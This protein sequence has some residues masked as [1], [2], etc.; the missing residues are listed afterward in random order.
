[1]AA[2]SADRQDEPAGLMPAPGDFP[3]KFLIRFSVFRFGIALALSLSNW[4]AATPAVSN[5]VHMG[6]YGA[7]STAVTGLM[8]QSFALQN[9]SGNIANSQTVGFKRVETSFEDMVPDG[10]PSKLASGSVV[11]SARSTN[12]VQGDISSSQ[13][14]TNMAINGNGFFVVQQRTGQVDGQSVFSGANLFTRRGDFALDKS[15]FLVNGA[16]N[17][18]EGLPVDPTT[19]NVSGSVPSVIKISN[20]LLPALATTAINYQVNLPQGA[21]L[22]NAGDF[23]PSTGTT[24]ATITGTKSLANDTP[25]KSTGTTDISGILGATPSPGITNGQGLKITIG[26]VSKTIA[27]NST[28]TPGVGEDG[29]LDATTATGADLVAKINSLFAGTQASL[30]PTT[31]ALVIKAGNNTDATS[32]ADETAAVPGAVAALG[33][34]AAGSPSSS[35][36]SGLSNSLSIQ[37]GTGTAV[38]VNLTGVKDSAGF[39]SAVQSAIG[40]SGTASINSST[41]DLTITAANTADK[42]TLSGTDTGAIGFAT[43]T[44]DPTPIPGT[45][46]VNTIK[47]SDGDKFLTESLSGG[48]I[49]A[50]APNGSPANVQFR[51]AKTANT[52][53]GGQDTWSLYY[54]SNPTA[55]GSNPM[56]TSTGQAYTF[57]ADGSLT[58]AVNSTTISNLTVGGV[59]LGDI[60]L[61]HGANGVTEF[62]DTNGTVSTTTLNQD[63]YA[64][65]KFTSVSI[66][67]SGRVVASYSNGQEVSVARVVTATFNGADSLKR[68]DGGAFAETTDSGSPVYSTNPTISGSSLE[69]SNTDISSEFSNLI[70]TQQAYA[71]G[72]KIV[73]TANDML[74]QALNMIR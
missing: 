56:W 47:A 57:G 74:Q 44:A 27:F 53:S 9:I 29:A 26:S 63:G 46:P 1:M 68:L 36:I 73:T 33:G 3:R 30:D 61:N 5:G 62:A 32:V 49:T 58:P 8:A 17:Y 60:T 52:T 38:A 2:K 10:I 6:I 12:T 24:P 16:G 39:L 23:L 37:F 18:L 67:N 65:G 7:L 42:I 64:A 11:A 40:S 15:G 70:V 25:A 59:A 20:S 71:A 48:A 21:S 31:H 54:G 45:G 34:L 28:A 51:W 66:D 43:T 69:A 72:T 13:I 55:T 22:M 35:V 50:Y 19:G 4:R 41:G 14:A